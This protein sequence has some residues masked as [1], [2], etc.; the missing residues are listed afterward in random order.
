MPPDSFVTWPPP[1]PDRIPRK[2]V[3][4]HPD[5]AFTHP[6]DPELNQDHVSAF[7]RRQQH[8]LANHQMQTSSVHRHKAFHERYEEHRSD[9]DLDERG[10]PTALPPRGEES[11]Q[12]SEGDRL[13]DFGVEEDV[14]FYDEDTV[15]L[16]ELLSRRRA[17][18]SGKHG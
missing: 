1:D 15:P 11:W 4:F 8:D 2:S 7:R 10:N 16:A 14:E 3:T 6:G 18:R 5:D 17:Q 9:D 12:N 13:D